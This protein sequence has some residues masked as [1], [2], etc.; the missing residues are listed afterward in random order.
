MAGNERTNPGILSDRMRKRVV[1]QNSKENLNLKKTVLD[2]STTRRQEVRVLERTKSDL[3][4]RLM[5]YQRRASLP[6]EEGVVLGEGAAGVDT[7]GSADEDSDEEDVFL[8]EPNITRTK[9]QLSSACICVSTSPKQHILP[10]LE[11]GRRRARILSEPDG[12]PRPQPTLGTSPPAGGF[13]QSW[14]KAYLLKSIRGMRSHLLLP[15]TVG[16]ARRGSIDSASMMTGPELPDHDMKLSAAEY[17]AMRRGSLRRSATMQCRPISV[18]DSADSASG[19]S[20][21]VLPGCASSSARERLGSRSSN[22]SGGPL[23]PVRLA[24]E[25]PPPWKVELDR[26]R[27]SRV[28]EDDVMML[29]ALAS[30]CTVKVPKDTSPE[31]KSKT[32]PAYMKPTDSSKRKTTHLLHPVDN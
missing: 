9:S 13:S 4:R 29:A 23:S 12:A 11:L 1:M 20:H 7:D 24:P 25:S 17:L 21:R 2:I 26:R 8:G 19:S 3:S 16:T 32:K 28:S 5:V 30:G 27:H 6:P 14:D 18:S 31:K 22:E 15:S 10:N